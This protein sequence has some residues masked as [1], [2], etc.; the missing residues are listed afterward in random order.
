MSDEKLNEL[1]KGLLKRYVKKSLGP[2]ASAHNLSSTQYDRY[3][4][5]DAAAYDRAH[6]YNRKYWNRKD[7]IERAVDRLTKEDIETMADE[8][9]ESGPTKKHFIQ[10]ANTVR[11]I[12]D[13]KK[14]QEFSDHHAGIFASQNPRFD[15]RRWHAACGT[16]TPEE[17][18]VHE[19][20]I[21]EDGIDDTEVASFADYAK[22]IALAAMQDKP[23]DLTQ[24]FGDAVRARVSD[25]VS[26][27]DQEVAETGFETV[28][29]DES[30][31]DEDSIEASPEVPEEKDI[32]QT[33]LDMKTATVKNV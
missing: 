28:E 14:R 21:D 23:E 29:P 20:V 6:K 24:V 11:A 12:E 13:P 1:S 9:N 18:E 16:K 4:N 33:T 26:D 8:L 27:F 31:E 10:V 3:N 19:G 25:M 22:A 7:G 17:R 2:M 32:E 5:G 15:H 30:E